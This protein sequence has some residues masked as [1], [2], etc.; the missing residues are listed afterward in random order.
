QRQLV[1]GISK[2][3][4]A[5]ELVGKQVLMVANMKPATIFGVKSNGMIL[6]ASNDEGDLKIT[7]VDGEISNG[8]QVK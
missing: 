5:D 8:A 3:Y 7:T 6:A 1:A 2:H 4:E